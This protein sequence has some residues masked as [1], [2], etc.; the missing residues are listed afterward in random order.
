M[1][2]RKHKMLTNVDTVNILDRPTMDVEYLC[3]CGKK[4]KHRQSLSL[5]KKKCNP[6]TRDK[7]DSIIQEANVDFLQ[8]TIKNLLEQNKQY[9]KIIENSNIHSVNNNINGNVT[10]NQ[11]KFNLNIFLNEE[12]KDAINITDYVNAIELTISDLE[13]TA[14]LGYIDG[15]S[16]IINDRINEIGMNQRPYHCT[17][18]KREIVYVKDKNIWEKENADKPKMK[19][20]I[21]T[22]I[23]KNL[24]LLPIWKMAHPECTDISNKKGEEYLH[25]MIEANGG[26]ERE[27][28]EEKILKNI[29][30]EA[31]L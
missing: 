30:K 15:I 13:E 25:M 26:L 9:V 23:N 4:Y 24:Q 11:T 7:D 6:E 14:R 22:I 8:N 31:I 18:S 28:K 12:C 29:M 2:T 27:K 10:V 16:K 20:M 1:S 3:T 17:D 21:T 19:Q 5:H